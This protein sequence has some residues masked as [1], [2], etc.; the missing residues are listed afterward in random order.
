MYYFVND[1]HFAEKPDDVEQN[2]ELGDDI[3]QEQGSLH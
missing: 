3:K 2:D 1:M